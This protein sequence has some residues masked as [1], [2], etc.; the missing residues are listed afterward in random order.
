MFDCR[1]LE[2]FK[3]LIIGKIPFRNVK[4]FSSFRIPMI[5]RSKFV[6]ST[7]FHYS[8]RLISQSTNIEVRMYEAYVIEI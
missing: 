4:V 3:E 5:K 6:R 2:A 1:I 8:V 7:K